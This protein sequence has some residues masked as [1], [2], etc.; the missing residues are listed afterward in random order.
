M[1]SLGKIGD[2]IVVVLAVTYIPKLAVALT[3][4]VYPFVSSELALAPPQV[5]EAEGTSL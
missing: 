1:K 4:K 5:N 2:L 3:N